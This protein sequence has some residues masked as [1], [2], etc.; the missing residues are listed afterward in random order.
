M[1]LTQYD[2]RLYN[3]YCCCVLNVAY[4]VFCLAVALYFAPRKEMRP[5]V[6]VLPPWWRQRSIL[7]GSGEDTWQNCIEEINK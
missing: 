7:E 6:K 1:K 4:C 5:S 2:K 3:T